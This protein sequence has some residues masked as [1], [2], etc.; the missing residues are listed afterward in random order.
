MRERIEGLPALPAA[1]ASTGVLRIAEGGEGDCW[2]AR[3]TPLSLWTL[4][5]CLV[6]PGSLKVSTGCLLGRCWRCAAQLVPSMFCTIWRR[7]CSRWGRA[8]HAP[9]P[10]PIAAA[11]V[12]VVVVVI[13]VGAVVGADGEGGRCAK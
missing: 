8:V 6:P 3:R 2:G 1:L 12:V 9:P 4:A 13:V 7:R 10:S 5:G 11:A